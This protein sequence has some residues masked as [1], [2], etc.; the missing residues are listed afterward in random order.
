M[1]RS[2][3]PKTVQEP[4]VKSCSRVPAASTTSARAASALACGAPVTPIGPAYS[5]WSAT[6]VDL[7]AIVSTT[8]TPCCSAKLRRR[9]SASE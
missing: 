9:A 1:R 3:L 7:P 4:V 8:G 2:S 5:G 6:S